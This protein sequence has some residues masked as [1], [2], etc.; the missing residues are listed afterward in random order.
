MLPGV[1]D[2]ELRQLL[3]DR[4]PWWRLAAVGRDPAAWAA[5]DPTLAGAA[6]VGIDYDPDVL[7]DVAL[8]GL[9]VLRGP[10]RVGKSVTAKR[11]VAR[12]CGDRELVPSQVIY[13]SADG[14]RAQDLRRAFV[15]GRDLT[16]SVGLRARV[17]VVD[18]VTAV[19][20]W[21]PVVKELRDNTPLAGDAVVLTGSS[22]VDLDEARRALGAGRTGV[23]T[24]FRLLLPMTF[25]SFLTTT[26]VEVPRPHPVG[27][28]ALQ[29]PEAGR[30]VR[31]LEPF[32]DVLD[33]A[34]QR[35]LDC[36]GF[37]R[38]VGEHH[39]RGAVS[40]EFVF[41][42]LSWLT[43][44]VEPDGAA[45]SVPRLLAE[46]HQRTGAPVD[47]RN[48]AAALGMSRDRLRV[49]LTRLVSTFAALWC[50]QADDSGRPVE[51]S[52][53]KL[54][55][56]DPLLA[57]LPALRDAA[58]GTAD[59]TKLTEAQ[60]AVELA[61]AVDRLHPDRLIEQRA[62]M[63]ARTG[64][65]NEVDFAPL[66]VHVS[67]NRARTIPVEGKWV[68]RNW[69]SEALV[70]RGRY[71]AGVLATKNVL[72]LDGEVWAV[73]APILAMLLN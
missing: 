10:R 36:G 49:R 42:L 30:A 73:P 65:G 16:A 32:C 69:R 68:T 28:D 13:C 40:P 64:S 21:V 48:T 45:E 53:S 11:L 1:R 31:E 29:T 47:L 39:H 22:A 43:A 38:A 19:P 26:D 4:N 3:R 51:G 17:W 50:A 37:P 27:P 46:L 9:W 71:G 60:L 52:Q 66:P 34:W 54:Y 23:A 33:L 7:A 41:D 70:M 61:R 20:G 72:D 58:F 56:F 15:L 6:A 8:P 57:H 55:L 14:F 63:Y 67:G 2:D 59:M 12:L 62:V 25:R 5:T 24:P 35:F 44:D 18:E